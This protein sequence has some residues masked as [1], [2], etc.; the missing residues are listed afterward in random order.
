MFMF[1]RKLVLFT[2]LFWAANSIVAVLIAPRVRLNL[3]DKY[4]WVMSR[5]GEHYHT[6]LVGSSRVENCI[7]AR[8]FERVTGK[9]C[10]NLGVGGAGAVDQYLLLHEFLRDNT[11]DEVLLQLDYLTLMDYF[12][13]GFRDY[14]WL[15][16][17]ENDIVKEA[18]IKQRGLTRYIVWK[19]APFVRLMEFSS[20]YRYFLTVV[21]PHHSAWDDTRGTRLLN[22]GG[23]PDTNFASF[24]VD[25]QSMDYLKKI[26]QLC[27]QKGIRIIAFQTPYPAVIETLTDRTLSDREIRGFCALERLKLHDFSRVF[28]DRPELFYDRHH[29][30]VG[31]SVA[32]SRLLGETSKSIED[33]N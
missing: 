6:A 7:D 33:T 1:L 20:Q 17:D 14:E 13:Y 4:H 27:R 31:G 24:H 16:Y 11:L 32:F 19:C 29:L 12:T 30:N 28:Y 15:C 2:L 10:I 9:S 22:S 8:E 21:P 18:L 23:Q 5:R 25:R 26:V 3:H